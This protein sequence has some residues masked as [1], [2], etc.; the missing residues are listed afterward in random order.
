M[1]RVGVRPAFLKA[2]LIDPWEQT[3]RSIQPFVDV[4]EYRISPF[5]WSV[6]TRFWIGSTTKLSTPSLASG[7]S[8]SSAAVEVWSAYFG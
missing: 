8:T 3:P 2:V 7:I 5:V 6:K 4:S 1:T